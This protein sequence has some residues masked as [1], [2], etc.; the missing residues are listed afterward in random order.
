MA[1]ARRYST[2]TLL[3]DG[4]VLATGGTPL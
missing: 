1:F 2:A 4:T 3:P